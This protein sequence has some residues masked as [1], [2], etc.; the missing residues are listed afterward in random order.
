[1]S[2]TLVMADAGAE[3]TAFNTAVAYCTVFDMS[4]TSAEELISEISCYMNYC[5]V[6]YIY[7]LYSFFGFMFPF[8]VGKKINS[9]S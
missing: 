5:C 6:A 3:Y 9:I 8:F 1:M 4:S 2:S 7:C